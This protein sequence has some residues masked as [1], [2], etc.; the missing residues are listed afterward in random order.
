MKIKKIKVLLSCFLQ[1]HYIGTES[2]KKGGEIWKRENEAALTCLDKGTVYEISHWNEWV[3]HPDY[4]ITYAE[5]ISLHESNDAF[6][7][8]IGN[9]VKRHA[10]K[11]DEASAKNY[12]FE[13]CTVFILLKNAHVSYPSNELNAAVD[14]VT[15]YFKTNI[16]YHG[17]AFYSKAETSLS[18]KKVP[19]GKPSSSHAV[20][21]EEEK[22]IKEEVLKLASKLESIGIVGKSKQ[23]TFFKKA[24]SNTSLEGVATTNQEE[25]KHAS[26]RK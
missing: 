9:L 16:H 15:R 1:R 3:N 7:T 17:Y 26:P 22:A 13:E 8:I 5:V 12:L 21:L 23:I 6:K 24:L 19:A 18:R 11:A 10:P 25:V 14:F 4:E 20:F 2:A